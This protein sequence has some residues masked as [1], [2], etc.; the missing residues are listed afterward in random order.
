LERSKKPS[1]H[2]GEWAAHAFVF[3]GWLDM[4]VSVVLLLLGLYLPAFFFSVGSMVISSVINVTRQHKIRHELE[5]GRPAPPPPSEEMLSRWQKIRRAALV[6]SGIV[7]LAGIGF[8]IYAVAQVGSFDAYMRGAA[9]V[10][11]SG[12]LA[13]ISNRYRPL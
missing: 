8:I 5:S 10:A 2:S 7:M 6:T 9:V 12:A 11:L 13:L 4:S 1:A 3:M